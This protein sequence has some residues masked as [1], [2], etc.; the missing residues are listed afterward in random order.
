[1]AEVMLMSAQWLMALALVG[2]GEYAGHENNPDNRG[3]TALTRLGA[4]IKR[5]SLAAG[6]P[7]VAVDLSLT[8]VT[9]TDLEQLKGL[10]DLR[11]LNLI[12]TQV[13]DAGLAHLQGLANLNH[14]LL[15]GS[16]ISDVGLGCL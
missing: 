1:M 6:K 8:A 13:T 11:A 4:K 7:V 12:G 2:I 16:Q 14:L 5:D 15:Q 9:D 3:V 10:T